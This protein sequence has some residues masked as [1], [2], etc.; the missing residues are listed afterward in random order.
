MDCTDY[1]LCLEVGASLPPPNSQRSVE[2]T[3]FT[4]SPYP[5]RPSNDTFIDPDL[6]DEVK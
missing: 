4:L 5:A 3:A 6:I 2:E 1:Q